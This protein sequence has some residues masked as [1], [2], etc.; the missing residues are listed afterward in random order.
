M[1]T[2]AVLV[3]FVDEWPRKRILGPIDCVWKREE[4][5]ARRAVGKAGAGINQALLRLS[6]KACFQTRIPAW[7]GWNGDDHSMP[8]SLRRVC[9]LFFYGSI[10]TLTNPA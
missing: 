10:Q 8:P 4:D 3:S 7:S 9:H 1:Q 5:C 6:S 2:I